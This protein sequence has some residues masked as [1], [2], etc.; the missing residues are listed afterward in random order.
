MKEDDVQ[1]EEEMWLGGLQLDGCCC[2]STS[3][4]QFMFT[5]GTLKG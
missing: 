3:G 4:F 5:D 2:W 1:E